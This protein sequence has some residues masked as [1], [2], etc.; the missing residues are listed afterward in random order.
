MT[1]ITDSADP[2]VDA[3]RR[4]LASLGYSAATPASAR[5]DVYE[6]YLLLKVVDAAIGHGY[7]VAMAYDVPQAAGTAPSELRVRRGPGYLFTDRDKTGSLYTHLVLLAPGSLDALGVYIGVRTSGHSG[8]LNEADVLVLSEA[9]AQARVRG[10]EHPAAEDVGIH[11][12]AKLEGGAVLLMTA[13]A[14]VGMAADFHG[15]RTRSGPL[16]LSVIA[17]PKVSQSALAFVNQIPLPTAAISGVYPGSTGDE[18][19]TRLLSRCIPS[20]FPAVRGGAYCAV[21]GQLGTSRS[22]VTMECAV[23]TDG[24]LRWKRK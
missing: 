1:S 15:R 4:A 6:A 11:M 9:V 14:F 16:R 20:D 23:A 19:L 10:I 12:E 7:Q 21:A 24:R 17:A 13:R 2:L 18:E 8:V 5:N 22:G 3:V